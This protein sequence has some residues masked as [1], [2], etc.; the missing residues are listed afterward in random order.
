MT[1]LTRFR[2]LLGL[3]AGLACGATSRAQAQATA[4]YPP[5]GYA[6]E[7][8]PEPAPPPEPVAFP[9]EDDD[10]SADAASARAVARPVPHRPGLYLRASLGPALCHVSTDGRDVG[11]I[12]GVGAAL[13]LAAGAFVIDNLAVFAEVTGASAL[14]PR[15]RGE[16]AAPER[17]ALTTL[18]GGAG[19]AYYLMP[20]NLSLSGALT[21]TQARAVDRGL[22]HLIGRTEFGPGL[23]L[24]AGKEW[25]VAAGWA[26]GLSLRGHAAWLK[27]ASATTSARTSWRSYGLS[28]ALSAIFG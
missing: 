9:D 24:T 14:D 17:T 5:P 21:L 2:F 26:V 4:P 25:S 15:F 13:S 12:T 7:W 6:A 8:Q 19:A 27:D 10:D 20:V 11:S 16:Q 22:G 23:Q 3:A 18:A 1:K 28:L